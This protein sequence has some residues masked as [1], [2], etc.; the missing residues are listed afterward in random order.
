MFVR[1]TISISTALL[2]AAFAAGHTDNAYSGDD[3]FNQLLK[4]DYAF[5]QAETCIVTSSDA[6]IIPT[7]DRDTLELLGDAEVESLQS[8]GISHFDG[9]GNFTS[10]STGIGI[11]HGHTQAGDFPIG[12]PVEVVC[13]GNYSISADRSFE[14]NYSCIL[15][16]AGVQ[17]AP[18]S[19]HGRIS[20]DKKTL[21]FA[22]T[23]P[24]IEEIK[25]LGT[26]FVVAERICTAVATDASIL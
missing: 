5:S 13:E 2:L 20:A 24:V 9:V 12:A 17:F 15:P 19:L 6:P 7:F 26:N 11:S 23:E 1:K 18:R 10:T 8:R 4:G 3:D 21:I 14:V 25:I 22:D 16:D